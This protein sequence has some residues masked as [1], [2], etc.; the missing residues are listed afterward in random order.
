VTTDAAQA[1]VVETHPSGHH[2]TAGSVV[3][4]EAQGTAGLPVPLRHAGPSR[5][6]FPEGVRHPWLRRGACPPWQR[7]WRAQRRIA[8][9]RR[10][11]LAPVCN[12]LHPPNHGGTMWHHAELWGGA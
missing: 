10:L 11:P 8:S 1:R 9:R 7:P 2:S 4:T 6:V 3:L 5:H 12:R